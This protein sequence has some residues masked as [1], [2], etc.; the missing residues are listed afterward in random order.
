MG[1]GRREKELFKNHLHT[2][3]PRI[4]LIDLSRAMKPNVAYASTY[5]NARD[6]LR[7]MLLRLN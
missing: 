5:Y 7:R 3:F 4:S 2:L 6:I 1:S